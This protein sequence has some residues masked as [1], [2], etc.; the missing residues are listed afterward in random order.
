MY[1][2]RDGN[3]IGCY[4]ARYTGRVTEVFLPYLIPLRTD[5]NS[6]S[7]LLSLGLIIPYE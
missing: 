6:Q 2:K 4:P 5:Y 1:E 3:L 7:G